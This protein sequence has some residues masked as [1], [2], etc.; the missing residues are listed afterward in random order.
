MDIVL[1]GYLETALVRFA[2]AIINPGRNTTGHPYYLC[3]NRPVAKAYF[4]RAAT[5]IALA[6]KVIVPSID[7]G[8]NSSPKRQGDFDAER[9][10][11]QVN[12]EDFGRREWDD[13]AM[14]FADILL[15]RRALSAE[16]W[17]HISTIDVSHLDFGG[18]RKAKKE[19]AKLERTVA[20]HYLCRLFLHVRATNDARS[21]L[22]LSEPDIKVLREI[23]QFLSGSKMP[24][25]FAFPDLTGQVF[26][27]DNFA[28]GLF[29]FSPLDALSLQAIKE[30]PTVKKYV[31]RVKAV[32]RDA[33]VEKGQREIISAM[34]DAHGAS[35]AAHKA[36]TV[37][38]IAGWVVKP[39]HYV[40]GIG[41]VLTFA[42]DA[43][44][45][46]SKW[47]GH[48]AKS[49]E[50]YLLG[51]KMQEISINDYLARKGNLIG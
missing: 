34:K 43:K 15:N 29:N 35:Q 25:P 4:D 47:V 20:H 44:D 30:D 19:K 48:D 49:W 7:W 50:W 13:D 21:M 31:S 36:E 16:S 12:G 23:G 18:P 39:L 27:A 45:L 11:L 32:L 22:V 6:D 26:D 17:R 38:E 14:L 46:V 9:L 8:P 42:E 1:G 51:A 40:P 5:F 41:E 33:G 3:L 28:S 10:G 37:F 24:I 2:D